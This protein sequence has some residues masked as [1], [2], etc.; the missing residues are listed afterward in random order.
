MIHVASIERKKFW[1]I[2][3]EKLI[4]NGEPFTIAYQK[5]DVNWAAINRSKHHV[6]N[7]AFFDKTLSV[8]F[9]IKERKVRIN[10]SVKYDLKM[11]DHLKA[12]K[13]EIESMITAPVEWISGT[14]NP[15]ALRIQ[16]LIPVEIG[17]TTN[18]ADVI[19]LAL[20]IIMD[21]IRVCERFADKQFF[22]F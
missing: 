19:D 6:E 13:T 8:D 18:Y 5:K 22:D 20:P 21:M 9:L 12:N 15:N 16:H 11:I 17:N 2:F 14:K 1:D 4:E 10:I 3:E 7:V